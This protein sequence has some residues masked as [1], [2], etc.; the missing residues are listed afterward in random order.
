MR[1]YSCFLAMFELARGK[2]NKNHG[3]PR[4]TIALFSAA[5]NNTSAWSQNQVAV[6]GIISISQF[7]TRQSSKHKL[8]TNNNMAPPKNESEKRTNAAIMPEA[9]KVK[10]GMWFF[11]VVSIGTTSS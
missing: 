1:E 2:G 7:G 10:I 8:T 6:V 11:L 3:N 4:S 9:G 5:N